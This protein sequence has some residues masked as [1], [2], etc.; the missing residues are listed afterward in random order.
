MTH[1]RA[2]YDTHDGQLLN[3][4]SISLILKICIIV[5]DDQN[6]KLCCEIM[7][8]CSYNTLASLLS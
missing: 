8:E 1:A 2:L 3:I 5:F 4:T 7:N 6:F